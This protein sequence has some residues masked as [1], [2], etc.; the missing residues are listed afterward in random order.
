[1]AKIDKKS[2][3][4]SRVV[5]TVE[6]KGPLPTND[7][8]VHVYRADVDPGAFSPRLA[9]KVVPCRIQKRRVIFINGMGGNPQ[10]HRAQA[11]AVSAVTG[12]PVWGVYN[13][14]DGL[15]GDLLQCIGDKLTG[16]WEMSLD[17]LTTKLGTLFTG[18]DRQ[19]AVRSQLIESLRDGY[20]GRTGNPATASLFDSFRRPGSRTRG[21]SPTARET[22]S[23]ATHSTHSPC[24]RAMPP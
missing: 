17:A 18:V 20:K 14:S 1:M 4:G 9:G 23:P 7:G 3:A 24:S 6:L 2:T 15:G 10:K 16:K 11:C 5:E 13:A 22:S 21:S 8:E 19:V 12:G